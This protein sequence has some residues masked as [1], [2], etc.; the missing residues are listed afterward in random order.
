MEPKSLVQSCSNQ[1]NVAMDKMTCEIS[2]CQILEPHF[3]LIFYA[4]F[5]RNKNVSLQSDLRIFP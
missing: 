3:S 4:F 1:T 2:P 5:L